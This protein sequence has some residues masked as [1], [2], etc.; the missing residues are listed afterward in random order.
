MRNF[1]CPELKA[2]ESFQIGIGVLL[3]LLCSDCA[4]QLASGL[5]SSF[6]FETV[7]IDYLYRWFYLEMYPLEQFC[8]YK[9][10]NF[11]TL[12]IVVVTFSMYLGIIIYV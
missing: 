10:V 8:P 3:L 4:G 6:S 1:E 2:S 5:V 12:F 9:A 7:V 11:L